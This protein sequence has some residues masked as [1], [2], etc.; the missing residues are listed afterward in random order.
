MERILGAEDHTFGDGPPP[1][2]QHL[3]QGYLDPGAGP[4][5]GTGQGRA[6]TPD[7][8]AAFS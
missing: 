6:L 5:T 3:V 4:A 1:F 2:T 8:R 7:E